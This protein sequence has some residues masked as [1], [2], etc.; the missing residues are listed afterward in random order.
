MTRSTGTVLLTGGTGTLGLNIA[1]QL[2]AEGLPTLV[3]AA[4]PPPAEALRVLGTLP[5]PV[6]FADGDVLNHDRLLDLMRANQVDTVIHAAA[7]TADPTM[8]T[9]SGD[10][11]LEVNCVG[12]LRAL[13]AAA[14]AG[15]TRFV[16]VGSVAAYGALAAE[17]EAWFEEERTQDRPANL[18]EISKQAAELSALRY[19]ELRGIQVVSARVGDVFGRWERPTPTR[20]VL[21]GPVQVVLRHLAGRAIVLPG[22]GERYW[23]YSADAA[24]AIVWLSRVDRLTHRVYNVGGTDRWSLLE[25]AELL[26]ASAGTASV[27]VDPARANVRLAADNPPLRHER[28]WADTP[29]RQRFDMRSAFADY[30]A[31]AR[32]VHLAFQPNS[33]NW[34]D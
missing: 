5:T 3:V 33:S 2:A 27:T 7:V 15:V 23:L 21:S 34:S 6:R 19:G 17:R 13:K 1:E 10:T 8:E 14:D 20:S 12:T 25:W 22:P 26:S 32:S 30:M 28:L 31:W 11:V 9:G 29:Y 18:Y 24:R 4:Q 16:Y